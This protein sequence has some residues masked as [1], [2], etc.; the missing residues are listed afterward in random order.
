MNV[1]VTGG[2][3]FVGQVVVRH[4]HEAGHRVRLLARNPKGATAQH[5]AERFQA[6][7]HAG[8]LVGGEGVLPAL[9]GM[10][11]IIH[12]VGIISEVGSQTFESVHAGATQTVLD[13]A[14]ASGVRRLVHMS[15]LGAR[16]GAV[17]RYHQ[18]KYAAEELVRGSDMIWTIFRPSLIYGPGDGFVNLFARL[19]RFS[20]VVPVIG[21]GRSRFQPVSVE[22][23]ARCFVGALSEPRAEGKT[24]DVCGVEALTLDEMVEIILRVTGRRRWRVR[25][26]VAVA[27][28]QAACL[29]RLYPMVLRRA[30][31]LNRD[32]IIMLEEGNVGDGQPARDLFGLV[33]PPFAVGT[34]AY[35]GSAQSH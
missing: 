20:P 28:V 19:S 7:L 14:R 18:T 9:A 30:P 3:G 12:L 10:D 31:P 35:L 24:F 2:T 25:L 22:V 32:Q 6:E 8:D 11:A 1:L 5:L 29:E 34:A 16:P 15:A 27:R 26:P 13:A 17:S 33:D 23:V 4:L 21:S